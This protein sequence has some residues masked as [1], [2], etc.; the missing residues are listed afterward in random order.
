MDIRFHPHA[1]TRLLERGTSEEEVRR[2]I[3]QGERFPAKLG[4]VGFRLNFAFNA[5]RLGHMYGTK[6]L[7]VYAVE[8]SGWLVITV[9][10]KFF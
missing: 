5:E 4:R 6:Q 2:T 3:Q 8:E 7:E 10:T 9:I 1:M